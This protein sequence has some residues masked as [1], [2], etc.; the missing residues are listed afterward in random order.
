[1]WQTVKKLFDYLYLRRCGV[2]TRYGYVTLRGLPRHP[3]IHSRCGNIWRNDRMRGPGR[4]FGKRVG[5]GV[6]C[7]IY[8]TD[9]HLWVGANAVLLK[10]FQVEDTSVVAC[11]A[12]VTK[13]A[14]VG[15]IISGNPARYIG[16]V[17]DKQATAEIIC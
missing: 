16:L 14:I 10:G 4:S 15:N 11:N 9:F 17:A 6:S 13:N 5:L 7:S 1:M 12:V 8:D 2:S 3:V